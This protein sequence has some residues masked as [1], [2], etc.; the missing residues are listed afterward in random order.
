MFRS[1]ACGAFFDVAGMVEGFHAACRAVVSFPFRVLPLSRLSA[2]FIEQT[3][4][5]E[6]RQSHSFRAGAQ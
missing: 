2:S 5:S 6:D 3:F 1:Q 4:V